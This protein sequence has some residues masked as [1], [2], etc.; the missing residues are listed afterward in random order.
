MLSLKPIPRVAVRE[1][2]RYCLIEGQ[3]PAQKASVTLRNGEVH[4]FEYN[5]LVGNGVH[6]PRGA[7]PEK[8]HGP[9]Y[10]KDVTYG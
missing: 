3:G 6:L 5:C 4:T 8:T 1:P 9:F 2:A 10:L 7:T